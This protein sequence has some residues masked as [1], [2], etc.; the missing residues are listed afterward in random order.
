MNH[1]VG[2]HVVTDSC[3]YSG[4]YFFILKEKEMLYMFFQGH[5][6]M[7]RDAKTDEPLKGNG[8]DLLRPKPPEGGHI[9]LVNI[10]LP[11]KMN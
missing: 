6:W 5:P 4:V 8:K 11:G 7:F 1:Q 2:L 3:Q 9:M 10:T